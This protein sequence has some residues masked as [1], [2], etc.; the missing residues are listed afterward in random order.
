MK[1]I[2][3][4]GQL[5]QHLGAVDIRLALLEIQELK[6][7]CREWARQLEQKDK[8]IAELE[9]QIE[10]AGIGCAE[11]IK[12]LDEAMRIF[13]LYVNVP[14][15]AELRAR[16]EKLKAETSKESNQCA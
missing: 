9:K 7:E 13:S 2:N 6:R 14:E 16:W 4:E 15:V 3:S 8:R 11:M 12:L 5:P 1:I 10:Y